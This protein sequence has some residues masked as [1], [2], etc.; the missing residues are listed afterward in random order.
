MRTRT[1]A[2][3]LLAATTVLTGCSSSSSDDKADPTTPPATA[4]TAT[5][6]L[7][8]GKAALVTA[9]EAYTAAFFKPDADTTFALLSKRC[10][11]ATS[12]T[13]MKQILAA[14]TLEYGTPAVKSTEVNQ[15]SGDM[16]RVTVHYVKP[17]LPEKP[18]SWTR[19]GG[20]WKFDGC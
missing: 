11:A 13:Q 17:P 10:Q 4:T 2:I 7:D 15:I 18:Q 8:D 14:S 12:V 19:E 6:K 9:A 20:A 3:A 16:G 5:P 1:A